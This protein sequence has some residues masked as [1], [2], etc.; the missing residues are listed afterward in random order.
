MIRKLV[1]L[2]LVSVNLW[3]QQKVTVYVGKKTTPIQKALASTLPFAYDAI[4]PSGFNEFD[5]PPVDSTGGDYETVYDARTYIGYKTFHTA[6]QIQAAPET[7]ILSGSS[8]YYPSLWKENGNYYLY[9]HDGSDDIHVRVATT[10]AGLSSATPIL[11]ASGC[12]DFSVRRSPTGTYVAAGYISSQA[13]IWT[14]PAPT[15]PFTLRGYVFG[16]PNTDVTQPSAYTNQADGMVFFDHYG[17]CYYMF[18]GFFAGRTGTPS[19]SHPVMF[20]ID[21]TTWRATHWPVEFIHQY[22]RPFHQEFA[23][24]AFVYN[25]VFVKNGTKEEM[26]YVGSSSDTGYIA[27]YELAQQ[28]NYE[29]VPSDVKLWIRD[30]DSTEIVSNRYHRYTTGGFYNF[31]NSSYIQFGT[32]NCTFTAT[33]LPDSSG[34]LFCLG[35]RDGRHIRAYV[36]SAS[37]LWVS[38]TTGSGTFSYKVKDIALNVQDTV[39]ITVSNVLGFLDVEINGSDKGTFP[40]NLIGLDTYSLYNLQTDIHAAGSQF[41]GIINELKNVQSS[42]FLIQ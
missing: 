19:T 41:H 2:L 5:I 30:G 37:E 33:S 25:P 29:P 34:L 18:N 12:S 4:H 10:I 23:S 40:G 35:D 6:A 28:S 36:N 8:N 16:D 3:A 13:C 11:V 1:I 9:Y 27:H 15:G 22:S 32:I 21:T 31:L 24:G 38:F 7:V 14:S 17:D 42:P 20:P 39:A 26:W